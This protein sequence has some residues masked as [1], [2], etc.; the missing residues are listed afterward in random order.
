[1]SNDRQL[2]TLH[3][4]MLACSV[5]GLFLC[6]LGGLANAGAHREAWFGAIYLLSAVIAFAAL[7]RVLT[8]R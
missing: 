4:W 3:A 6:G 1:M 7:A 2:S 5:I 8:P